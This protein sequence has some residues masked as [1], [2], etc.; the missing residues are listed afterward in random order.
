[1]RTFH[2][3]ETDAHDPAFRLTFGRVQANAERPERA[4]LLLAAA[5]RAGLSAEAPPEHDRS[6]L[7]AVHTAR[8]LDYLETAWDAWHQLPNAAEEIIPN[9]FPRLG[10]Q[11]YP[12]S[13][14]GRA[15]WH[16]GDVSAPIGPGSWRATR[17]AADCALAAA[18][19]VIAGARS[20]YALCRPPGHHTSAEVAAGHCLLNVS[21]IAA[22]RMRTA[23]ERVAIL[24][25]DTHHGNGTQDIFYERGDV[26]FVSVHTETDNYYPFFTGYA[27]ETG[28]GD[29]DG[30]TLNLPL[31]QSTEDEAW[32][33]AIATGLERIAAFAPGALILSL[34][35]DSHRDDPLK[36]MR[37]GDAGFTRAAGLIADL[38]LPTVL[39]QE[40][41]YLSDSLGA[42]LSAFLDGWLPAAG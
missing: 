8:F 35:L 22:A 9:T 10:T 39:V 16:A 42:A 7:E 11:R 28:H 20:S 40:G 38:G 13:I 32:C 24:D 21:A 27:D 1:M 36:G 25:I 6:A 4:R 2:A 14:V 31:P 33:R 15:G 19:T 18:D 3:T 30:A 23:H 34:G 29:G 5:A 17:R 12:D 41:G 26:L 37:V